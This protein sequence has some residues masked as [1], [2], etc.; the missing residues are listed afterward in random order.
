[1]VGFT[2]LGLV[3]GILHEAL[4][5][6]ALGVAY[7]ASG[8]LAGPVG[9]VIAGRGWLEPGAAHVAG[10]VL[11]GIAIFLSLSV[12][13]RLADRRLG[14][15]PRGVVVAWNRNLGA[16]AGFVFGA[17]LA[18]CV[19]CLVD[20]VW[21][22]APESEGRWARAARDSYLRRLV[23]PINPADRFLVTDS[24][25]LVRGAQEDPEALH[26]LRQRPVFRRLVRHPTVQAILQDEEL[27]EAI[28]RRDVARV[29][30]DEKIHRLLSDPEVRELIFSEEMRR[31]LRESAGELSQGADAQT[32]GDSTN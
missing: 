3:R 10:R 31:V 24:L 15:T 9:G 22:A 27:M 6:A 1:M 26:G 4:M 12:A 11:G 14:R 29:G 8:A 20:A 30:R 19:L 7:A 25:K 13:V 21:K 17:L 16:L 18:F 2:L 32:G 5:V 23:S 28:R